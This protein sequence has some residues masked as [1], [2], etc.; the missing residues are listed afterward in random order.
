MSADFLDS[1]VLVYTLDNKNAAKQQIASQLLASALR[2]GS[3]CISFQGVQETLNVATR[4]LQ[5]P[6]L[7][8]DAQALLHNLLMPLCRVMPSQPLYQTA[9]DLQARWRY[10]FYDSL[11]I[12]AALQAGCTRLLSEDLQHG[13]QIDGLR[14]ENPFLPAAR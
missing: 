4:R 12:A 9:L 10:S 5:P 2:Q 7:A 3:A 8:A 14:I 11:V 13:Q 1:N 6:L